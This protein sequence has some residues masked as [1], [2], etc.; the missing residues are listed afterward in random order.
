MSRTPNP[1]SIYRRSDSK[2]FRLTLSHTSGLPHQM[3]SDWYMRSYKDFPDELAVYRYPKSKSEAKAGA[4]ALIAY[5]K[6]TEGAR[7]PKTACSRPLLKI[8]PVIC[9][10]RECRT[11]PAGPPKGTS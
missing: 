10:R 4:V 11:L 2:T 5:L 8:S 6:K 3:C 1:Y 9:S 7:N